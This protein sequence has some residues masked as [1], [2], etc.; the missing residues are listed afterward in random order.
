MRYYSH[1]HL[2]LLCNTLCLW[3]RRLGSLSQQK[4]KTFYPRQDTWLCLWP[5]TLYNMSYLTSF[6][7]TERKINE[8]VCLCMCNRDGQMERTLI[9]FVVEVCETLVTDKQP[10]NL[11]WRLKSGNSNTMH[12]SESKRKRAF[13]IFVLSDNVFLRRKWSEI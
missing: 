5:V 8:F 3:Y 9:I 6:Y 4:Q 13:V 2:S 12:L 10:W 11:L 1:R 7:D